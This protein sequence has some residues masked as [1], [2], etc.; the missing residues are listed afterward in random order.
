VKTIEERLSQQTAREQDAARSSYWRW[1][2]AEAD[3]EG[4]AQP[5]DVHMVRRVLRLLDLTAGDFATD[6]HNVQQLREARRAVAAANARL[7]QVPAV[8]EA[9][10]AAQV[11]AEVA[12][13]EAVE[14]RRAAES[15]DGGARGQLGQAEHVLRLAEQRLDEMRARGCPLKEP[16]AADAPVR[17]YRLTDKF[18]DGDALHQAGDVIDFAGPPAVCMELVKDEDGDASPQVDELRAVARAL[19]EAGRGDDVVALF[20]EFKVEKASKCSADQ[21]GALLARL[22]GLRSAT[23]NDA[24]DSGGEDP[25]RVRRGRGAPGAGRTRRSRQPAL[26]AVSVRMSAHKVAEVDAAAAAVARA[27]GEARNLGGIVS[28]M[29]VGYD[30][31]ATGGDDEADG[32]GEL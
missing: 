19:I 16:A 27:Y 3:G 9:F 13:A 31:S 6:V 2:L 17:R 10:A 11:R 26:P 18:W 21:R 14:A 32:C 8:H 15:E 7:A 12:A 22:T 20:D 4:G 24:A 1:V 5:P 25:P 29:A 23:G 28:G 30:G